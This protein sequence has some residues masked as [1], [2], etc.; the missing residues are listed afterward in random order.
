MVAIRDIVIRD[1]RDGTR[2]GRLF[3]GAV[4]LSDRQKSWMAKGGSLCESRT[5]LARHEDTRRR[6][7]FGPR[8]LRLRLPHLY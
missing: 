7:C 3:L 6:A 5:G 1:L 8:P 4:P 2:P